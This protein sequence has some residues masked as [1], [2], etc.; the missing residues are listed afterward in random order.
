MRLDW[1]LIILKIMASGIITKKVNTTAL[2]IEVSPSYIS[3]FLAA[4]VKFI[5]S[6]EHDPHEIRVVPIKIWESCV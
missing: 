2:R 4:I 6:I 3:F 1:R 5:T